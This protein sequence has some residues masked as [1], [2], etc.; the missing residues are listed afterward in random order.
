MTVRQKDVRRS[1][2]S[3]LLNTMLRILIKP[4]FKSLSTEQG[5]NIDIESL[6]AYIHKL[7]DQWAAYPKGTRIVKG[8]L[9]DVPVHRIFHKRHKAMEKMILFIH[10]GGFFL[11][12]PRFHG[13][14]V[15]RLARRCRMKAVMPHYRLAPE[16]PFP[17]AVDDILDVYRALINQGQDPSSIVVVGDSAGGNL[18]LVLLQQALKEG[19]PQ[20]AG[21]VMI[22]PGTDLS[23]RPANDDNP[24]ANKDP[25]F[26][27]YA[28]DYVSS[29]LFA[30]QENLAHDPR[31]S[32]LKG[33]FAGLCPLMFVAGSTEI[34]RD[35]SIWA[36]EKA[37]ANG[38]SAVCDI[39]PGMPHDFPLFPAEILPEAERAT[40]D[41]AD[42]ITRAVKGKEERKMNND[43]R[44]AGL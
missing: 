2:R 7:I 5:Q 38:V 40:K 10:G 14:F 23:N 33:D 22:S 12:T 8:T 9:G 30:G 13:A 41:I 36:T 6:R 28:L 29:V 39:W 35:H 3:Y 11:E 26:N 16:Y 43:R 24:I 17:A 31:V 42:F 25:M 18:T 37:K 44:V 20:P 21:A 32:P 4:R 27:Q 34:L 19:L 1:L 15:G